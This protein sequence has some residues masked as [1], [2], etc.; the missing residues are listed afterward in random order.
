MTLCLG[1]T[2]ERPAAPPEATA[3]TDGAASLTY[4]ELHDLVLEEAATLCRNGVGPGSLVPLHLT[5]RRTVHTI[6]SLLAILAA[7]AAFTPVPAEAESEPT[8]RA[9]MADRAAW[10]GHLS[11]L[12]TPAY[13]L[14]TSGSTGPA[15]HTVVTRESLRTVFAGLY[16]RLHD[17]LPPLATWTQLH[18]LTFGFS[19]C[20]V[21]GSLTFGGTLVLVEREEPVTFKALSRLLSEESGRHVVCLTP[22]ELSVLVSAEDA[23]LPSHLLLSG[24]PA[25]RAPLR[26]LFRLAR[27]APPVVVNT[28]A[29]TETSGQVTA[30][31][32][33]AERLDAVLAGHVGRPIPG[34][35]VVLLGRDDE[36]IPPGD[37]FTEGEIEVR[38]ASVSAGYLDVAAH[39]AKFAAD[40]ARR[41]FRTGD[42]GRWA[43][44]GGL[45]VTGRSE[46]RVKL[47]GRWTALDEIERALT[48]DGLV[49]EAVAA[50]EEYPVDGSASAGRLLVAVVPTEAARAETAVQVR[51]RVL[52][53][54]G[55]PVT[56][57]TVVHESISRTVHGKTDL[58][59]LRRAPRASDPGTGLTAT[60]MGVWTEL[61][62]SGFSTDTNLFE[63]GVDS[64]GVVA[65]AIRLTRELGREISPSF[66]FDHPRITLQI[67]ALSDQPAQARSPV[68]QAIPRG[69][70]ADRRRAARRLDSASVTPVPTEGALP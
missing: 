67:K 62:G 18:P 66:L 50:V 3:L 52:R 31:L 60:V 68:R 30:D 43:V 24:E 11:P 63:S 65:A 57:R 21:I 51:R 4:A 37:T 42:R 12:S 38:G 34:V 46:R 10:P 7:G 16:A 15:K 22:S 5:E 17:Q 36:P 14:S 6:V 32:V 35:E 53:L 9:I 45:V 8:I 23:R 59:A 29:A 2:L 56:L 54:L 25:H 41:A 55:G 20:E 47:A 48:E 69:S 44:D 61:L 28:Y 19:I 39:G 64:L 58:A 27:G 49:A 70:V 26:D 40:D 13:I 1:L 33:T